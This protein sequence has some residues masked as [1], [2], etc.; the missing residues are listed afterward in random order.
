MLST[1][2]DATCWR[3]VAPDAQQNR[4]SCACVVRRKG[5]VAGPYFTGSGPRTS[6]LNLAA[7]NYLRRLFKRIVPAGQG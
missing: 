1:R 2:A 6:A 5:M 7:Y 3:H 4:C